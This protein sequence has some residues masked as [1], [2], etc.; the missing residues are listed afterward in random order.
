MAQIIQSY[1]LCLI[2]TLSCKILLDCFFNTRK[3]NYFFNLVVILFYNVF[4]VA[5]SI[6][7][8]NYFLKFCCIVVLYSIIYC[9]IYDAAVYKVVIASTAYCALSICIETPFYII[10]PY[11]V[12]ACCTVI[13]H[14]C[15]FCRR[16]RSNGFNIISIGYFNL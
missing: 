2:T 5:M 10:F 6:N 4:I 15:F 14:I 3:K 9:V 12:F 16:N 7:C 11:I 1:I 13:Y 8:K